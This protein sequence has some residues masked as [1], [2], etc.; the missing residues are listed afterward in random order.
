LEGRAGDRDEEISKEE[1]EGRER[2]V[3]GVRNTQEYSN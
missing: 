3:G 2:R 1:W